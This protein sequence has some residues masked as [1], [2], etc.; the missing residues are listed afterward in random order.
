MLPHV[1]PGHILDFDH[2]VPSRNGKFE[3]FISLLH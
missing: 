1:L 2:V 3:E